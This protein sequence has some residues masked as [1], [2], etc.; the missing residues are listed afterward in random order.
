MHKPESVL[1]NKMHIIIRGFEIQT[2]HLIPARRSDLLIIN[3]KKKKRVNQM[4]DL[5]VPV[6]Y[7]VKIK[8][9]EKRD[10][11]LDLVSEQKNK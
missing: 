1:E 7:R 4:E 9:N 8:E 5:S 11:Y 3:N 2:D 6:D 10:K